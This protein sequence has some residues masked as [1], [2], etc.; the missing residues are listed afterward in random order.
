MKITI[1][2]LMFVLTVSAVMAEDTPRTAPTAP[3]ASAETTVE[4][5]MIVAAG[6]PRGLNDETDVT[7]LI[8]ELQRKQQQLQAA[9]DEITRLR[10]WIEK[11]KTVSQAEQ[12]T[13][14]YNMGCMYKLY[15]QFPKAEVEFLKAL[16]VSPDDPSIHYNLGILYD[17]DLENVAGAK[18]HYARFIELSANEHDRSQVQ[19][20]LTSLQ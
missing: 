13:M 1:P 15:K 10:N 14:H 18:K 7:G 8:L 5:D 12:A 9:L 2:L 16:K 19:E 6:D 11:I 17:D 4:A 20:W 3:V